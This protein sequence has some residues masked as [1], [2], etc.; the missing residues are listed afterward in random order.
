MHG[1]YWIT[2]DRLYSVVLVILKV[3]LYEQ[4]QQQQKD[5]KDSEQKL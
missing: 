1:Y 3:S 5:K 4:S 2:Q